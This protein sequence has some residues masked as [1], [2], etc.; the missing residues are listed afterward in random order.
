MRAPQCR[1]Y[2]HASYQ[3]GKVDSKKIDINQKQIA[4]PSGEGSGRGKAK[5]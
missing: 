2:R 4:G 3:Q 1:L 5:A